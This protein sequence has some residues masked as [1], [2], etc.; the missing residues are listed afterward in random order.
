MQLMQPSIATCFDK[1]EKIAGKPTKTKKVK[2]E[3]GK[4]RSAN[5]WGKLAVEFQLVSFVCSCSGKCA[6]LLE[7]REWTGGLR[8]KTDTEIADFLQDFCKRTQELEFDDD[9]ECWTVAHV[10]TK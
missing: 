8:E 9:P 4:T 10:G 3:Q 5:I 1:E 6:T 2:S 7:L